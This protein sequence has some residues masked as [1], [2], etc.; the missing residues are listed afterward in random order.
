MS[1]DWTPQELTAA[2]E[3]MKASGH[4]SYDE[5]CE[6]LSAVICGAGNS[7][8]IILLKYDLSSVDANL[9][10]VNQCFSR[11]N[12]LHGQKTGIDRAKRP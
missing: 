6:A 10:T 12:S 8:S 7:D 3:A 1:R 9:Q 11:H 5:F 4:M 2:S